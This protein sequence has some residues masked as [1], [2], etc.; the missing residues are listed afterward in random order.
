MPDEEI[1]EGKDMAQMV[2]NI[3]PITPEIK[4]MIISLMDHTAEAYTKQVWQW[5]N[6]RR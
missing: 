4:E 3:E 2:E 1:P 6:Y 5:N